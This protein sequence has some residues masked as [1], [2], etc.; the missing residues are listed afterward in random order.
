MTATLEQTQNDLPRLVKLA[1][2]GEE[3]L[4]TENGKAVARITSA[5][6][7]PADAAE[8]PWSERKHAWL[9]ELDELR[10]STGSGQQNITIQEILDDD[11]R[12]R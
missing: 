7:A 2:Q 5:A 4:I 6:E 12:D 11:R 3:V 10:A 1:Q 9:A 8:V